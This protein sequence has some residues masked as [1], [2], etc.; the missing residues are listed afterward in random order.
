MSSCG[1]IGQQHLAHNSNLVPTIIHTKKMTS[2]EITILTSFQ[3][4][5]AE[6]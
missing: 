5:L 2:V 3:N 1:E 4:M 6:R